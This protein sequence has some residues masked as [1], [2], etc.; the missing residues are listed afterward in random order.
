MVIDVQQGKRKRALGS[1]DTAMNIRLGWGH[2]I[3][4]QFA[5]VILPLA[6]LLTVRA[7][8]DSRRSGLLAVT[9]PLHLQVNVASKTYKQFVDGVTDAV[10]SGKLSA[11]AVEALH[12]SADS[13][14][15]I[16]DS[17]SGRDA[18]ALDTDLAQ[19]A[20]KLEASATLE[21]LM[22]ERA[23]INRVDEGL[24]RLDGQYEN[25]TRAVITDAQNGARRQILAV[26]VA[27]GF[28]LALAAYFVRTMIA[29]L[30]QP[31]RDGIRIAQAIA[32][33]DLSAA[34]RVDGQDE[35]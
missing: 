25:Q 22:A 34:H 19:M 31:L 32:V 35:T 5:F 10:D 20:G 27:G 23:A 4:A 16:A 6:I 30:T 17:P 15:Q 21:T 1:E 24:S 14:H 12:K 26:W 2:K 3:T 33:G 9:F 29:R 8:M 13:L 11:K 28:A 18:L 7:W